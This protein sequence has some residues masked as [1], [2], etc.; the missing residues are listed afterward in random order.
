MEQKITLC[1]FFT[2]LIGRLTVKS[3][4]IAFVSLGNKKS[5]CAEARKCGN[6]GVC[7]GFSVSAREYSVCKNQW[8]PTEW[9]HDSSLKKGSLCKQRRV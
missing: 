1:A 4:L 2:V 5:F 7:Y 3:F 8:F 9:K 6:T